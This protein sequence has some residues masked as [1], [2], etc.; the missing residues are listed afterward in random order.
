[1]RRIVILATVA[2][3]LSGLAGALA[4]SALSDEASAALFAF[5]R[6]TN[7]D[8]NGHIRVHEQ[9]TA[10]VN[11][12]NGSVLVSGTVDVGNFPGGRV[13]LM[14]EN[15]TIDPEQFQSSSFTQ[16]ADCRRLAVFLDP[17]PYVMAG[18]D[19][20]ALLLSAGGANVVGR[21]PLGGSP[22]YTSPGG[23]VFYYGLGGSFQSESVVSPATALEFHN[24]RTD[25]PLTVN[26]AWL[27]C[28]Q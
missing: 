22:V 15:L 12:T 8:G 10:D 23:A 27:F 5:V 13:V 19:P 3:L 24:S 25:I 9:G 17:N 28:S 7:V 14:A 4:F 1:M 26:K 2:G 11:V 6:E 20:P 16:T 21:A 18:L